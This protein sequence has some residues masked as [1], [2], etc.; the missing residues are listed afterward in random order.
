M[1]E[2]ETD[3]DAFNNENKLIL[4]IKSLQEEFEKTTGKKII[5]HA[6]ENKRF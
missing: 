6:E 5:R 2:I 4:E 1:K 3:K